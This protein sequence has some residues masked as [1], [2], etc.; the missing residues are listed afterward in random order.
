MRAKLL[1]AMVLVGCV[2]LAGIGMTSADEKK[3]PVVANEKKVETKSEKY[4][5]ASTIDFGGE[6]GLSFP[7][8]TSLGGRIEAARQAADPVALAAAGLELAAAEKVS[9]KKAAL[10]ADAV[11]KEAVDLAKARGHSKELLM[12]AE[13]VKG[14]AA[15]ELQ[16]EADK[17]AQAE[18]AQADK[19]EEAARGTRFLRVHN[20]THEGVDIYVNGQF[21]GHV[22]EHRHET[23]PLHMRHDRVEM[24]AR[25]HHRTWGPARIHGE[26]DTYT[27]D[28]ND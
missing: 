22:H 4:T 1:G 11:L 5:P 28:L 25:H 20:H 3:P 15:K 7:S 8:L 27:W 21:I 19:P 17:A 16:T 18:K 23:F 2:V 14:D 26:Y 10:A 12:V 6:L 9:G 13:M 24:L